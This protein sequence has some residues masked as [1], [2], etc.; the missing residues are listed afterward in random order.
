MEVLLIQAKQKKNDRFLVHPPYGLLYLASILRQAGHTV[1]IYDTNINADKSAE[2][3]RQDIK[4]IIESKKS[5]VV[6]VGGMTSSFV[7][8]KKIGDDIRKDFPGLHLILG[9]IVVSVLPELVM[10]NTVYDVGCIGEAE[11]VIV[12]ICEKLHK[13]QSL[14]SI[15]GLLLRSKD[16]SVYSTDFGVIKNGRRDRGT[17][18]LDEIPLPS[19]DLIDLPEYLKHQSFCG[20]LFSAYLKR[21]GLA[22]KDYSHIIPY[23]MP[24]FAGRG[25][26]FQCVFCY[27]TMHKKPVKHSVKYVMDHFKLLNDNYGINHFQ[28]MDE[29]VN[30]DIK[31]LKDLCRALIEQGSPYFITPGNR[32]R[33]SFFDRE[34]LELMRDANFYDVGVGVESLDDRVLKVM[35]RKSTVKQ[36]VADLKLIKEYGIDQQHIRCLFGFSCDSWS[37]IFNSIRVGNR[38]G[39]LTL[40]AVVMPLPG[41]RL[42]YD[43]CKNGLIE[44][45]YDYMQ[46]IYDEDGYRNMTKYSSIDKVKDVVIFANLFSELDHSVRTMCAGGFFYAL[47]RMSRFLA[48]R[49]FLKILSL[50][51]KKRG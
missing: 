6:G 21:R 11:S 26:P 44:N 3:W 43:C 25:C 19:Y 50:F 28:L 12:D 35:N 8:A 38:L 40:H 48:K 32:N 33:N 7:C 18:H 51:G 49:L 27:S 15:P 34:M 42:Y 30:I 47:I 16:G 13:K 39:Y 17:C 31:W 23:G 20:D 24:V 37:T 41:T 22:P 45:E 10:K 29:N 36:L 2:G 9:G 46:E 14:D 1:F 4:K 5:D